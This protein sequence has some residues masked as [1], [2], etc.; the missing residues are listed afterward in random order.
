[1]LVQSLMRISIYASEYKVMTIVIFSPL[2]YSLQS[3]AEVNQ[4]STSPISHDIL[5]HGF[6][7]SQ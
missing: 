2:D 6:T 7:R 3:M 5:V 4:P 1:M